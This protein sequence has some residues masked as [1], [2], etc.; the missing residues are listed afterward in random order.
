[1]D[2]TLRVFFATPII[3]SVLS[4]SGIVAPIIHT[5][6]PPIF[7]EKFSRF[8]L[9][10]LLF[11]SRSI[12]RVWFRCPGRGGTRLW[13]GIS[14]P[15]DTKFIDFH[16][17]PSLFLDLPQHSLVFFLKK[18]CRIPLDQKPKFWKHP[19]TPHGIVFRRIYV[20]PVDQHQILQ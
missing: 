4:R 5:L 17:S 13:N 7:C 8:W 11:W 6:S 9:V 3:L 20:P 19:G 1:M 14:A 2:R 12:D 18:S 16:S 15:G 10:R